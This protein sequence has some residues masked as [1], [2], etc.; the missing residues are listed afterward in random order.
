MEKQTSN[1]SSTNQKTN[2]DLNQTRMQL[3]QIVKARGNSQ[4][5]IGILQKIRKAN[6]IF[7]VIKNVPDSNERD[8][9]K[10]EYRGYLLDFQTS[11]YNNK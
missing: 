7:H 1:S 5:P 2:S 11:S 8:I 4:E 6:E 9:L 10:R 3:N